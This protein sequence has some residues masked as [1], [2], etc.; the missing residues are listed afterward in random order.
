MS[1]TSDCG[2]VFCITRSAYWFIRRAYLLVHSGPL[3][4]VNSL[5]RRLISRVSTILLAKTVSCGRLPHGQASVALCFLALENLCRFRHILC[6]ACHVLCGALTS[7]LQYVASTEL[8]YTFNM[9]ST[10]KGFRSPEGQPFVEGLE[11]IAPRVCRN[12]SSSD[13]LLIGSRIGRR[14]D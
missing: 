4:R 12:A 1:R 2:T 5:Y 9:Y 11:L 7:F 3:A 6:L 8:L 13:Q 10:S 14:A